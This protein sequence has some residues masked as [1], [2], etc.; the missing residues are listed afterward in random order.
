MIIEGD[1]EHRLENEDVPKRSPEEAE[2]AHLEHAKNCKIRMKTYGKFEVTGFHKHG[3]PIVR[4]T[5]IPVRSWIHDDRKWLQ[6]LV[7][8]KGKKR[9]VYDFKDNSTTEKPNFL[10]HWNSDY[11]QPNHQN[12]HLVRSFGMSNIT[13][14]D[15]NGFPEKFDN[16]TAVLEAY[17]E[18][19]LNH[20]SLVKNT[21]VANERARLQD[22]SYKIK[23]I[24]CVLAN[25]IVIMKTS[26]ETIRAKMT[27]YEIPYEY[28]EK[29]KSRDFSEE[30]L[31]KNQ[32][33]L[34]QCKLQLEFAQN[35]ASKQI[36]LDDLDN[37]EK[38]I[39][40]RMK[41]GVIV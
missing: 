16:I 18:V 19:M 33:L 36:W 6:S 39:K 22:I 21:R 23:F 34:K 8:V 31:R 37:L 38:V 28:Y 3:G 12:L 20:Y 1:D 32:E 24:E 11:C 10:I 7:A 30:S 25:K 14:I 27:E 4:I 35:K 40:K 5:E 13:L 41:N 15:H 17:F 29:S 26:E 2:D 9:P